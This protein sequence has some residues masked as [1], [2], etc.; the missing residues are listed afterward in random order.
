MKENAAAANGRANTQLDNR[1]LAE[2]GKHASINSCLA[3]GQH[4]QALIFF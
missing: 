4:R 3:K 2:Y 1:Q